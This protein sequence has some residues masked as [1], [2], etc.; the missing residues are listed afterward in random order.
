MAAKKTEKVKAAEGGKV[1]GVHKKVQPSET[2]AAIV[3]SDPIARG[4]VVSRMWTYIKDNK[5][6]DPDDG[7]QIKADDKLR[8]IFK[9][10]SISMFEMNKRL[11]EHLS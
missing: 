9:A 7:R 1:D 4:E 5:L 6:Q 8:P 10:D 11:S 2:L 3:G